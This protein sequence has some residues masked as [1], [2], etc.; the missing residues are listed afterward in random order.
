VRLADWNGEIMP[1]TGGWCR[2]HRLPDDLHCM[3]LQLLKPLAKGCYIPIATIEKGRYNS[4]RQV[5]GEVRHRVN[6]LS[7]LCRCCPGVRCLGVLRLCLRRRLGSV[8][9]RACL[10]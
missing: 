7:P 9:C 10:L 2:A 5:W 6:W 3:R 4:G 1:V 8:R